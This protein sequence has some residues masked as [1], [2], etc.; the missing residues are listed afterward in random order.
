MTINTE[1]E[2]S[3]DERSSDFTDNRQKI[4]LTHGAFEDFIVLMM[5]TVNNLS[6]RIPSIERTCLSRD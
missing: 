6:S 1:E 2:Q 3:I 4:H 5:K